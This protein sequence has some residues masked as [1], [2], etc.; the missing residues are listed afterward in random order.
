MRN[1]PLALL[2]E[3]RQDRLRRGRRV[4]VDGEVAVLLR[5][6]IRDELA[7]DE[8]RVVA[9]EAEVRARDVERA[10]AGEGAVPRDGHRIRAVGVLVDEQV[11]PGARG[12][13][14]QS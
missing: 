7:T 4:V 1:W 14:G 3:S 2:S 5:D 13:R 8:G 6:R 9:V 10:R 11:L 12:L